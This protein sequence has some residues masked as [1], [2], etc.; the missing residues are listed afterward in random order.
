MKTLNTFS[1]SKTKKSNES[2]QSLFEFLITIFII[3][4]C[5]F[6]VIE[7]SRF[8]SFKNCLQAS[9]SYLAHKIAYNQIDLINKR[10]L[11]NEDE[12]II[13]ENN[14]VSK[15]VSEEIEKTLNT[16]ATSLIS[17]DF[18]DSSENVHTIEKYD[19][20]VN[21]KI[22]NNT[23]SLPSGVYIEAQTCLPILFAGFFKNSSQSNEIGKVSKFKNRTC[24][25]QFNSSSNLPL[26]WLKVRVAAYSPWTPALQILQK[27]IATPE[28]FKYLEK[29]NRQDSIEFINSGHLL[30]YFDGSF[31]PNPSNKN[32]DFFH[33]SK[34]LKLKI[35][36]Q[37]EVSSY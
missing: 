37:N 9:T 31:I 35:G 10:L 20:R 13:D 17:F 23:N 36:G 24:L 29:E 14:Q 18:S 32:T 34:N 6:S 25:G 12:I 5:T 19:V 22:I 2:G 28:Q 30:E 33:T 16:I 21:L 1:I 26:S 15:N 27:G 8:I 4:L 11:S 3:I 7:I